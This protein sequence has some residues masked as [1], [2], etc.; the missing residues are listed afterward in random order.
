[1]TTG[2]IT[3][4]EEHIRDRH[5]HYEVHGHIGSFTATVE[6]PGYV[7]DAFEKKYGKPIEKSGKITITTD[8][9]GNDQLVAE[10]QNLYRSPSHL[11]GIIRS[12][13]AICVD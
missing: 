9:I 8:F 12:I 13:D 10:C 3:C 5:T 1:M 6:I 11:K 2:S 7:A 4:L